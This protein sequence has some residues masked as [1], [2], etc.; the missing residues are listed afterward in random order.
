MKILVVCQYYKPEPFRV[1]DICEALVEQGH[2]VT[3]L[4]GI[5]NYPMGNIYDGY[6]NKQKRQENLNGVRV[7]RH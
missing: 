5:P 3:V 6:Q 1:S 2:E 4:T 7:F